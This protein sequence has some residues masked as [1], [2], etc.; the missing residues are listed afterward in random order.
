MVDV[1]A[2]ADKRRNFIFCFVLDLR[3]ETVLERLFSVESIRH[4]SSRVPDPG[5]ERRIG[6][7]FLMMTARWCGPRVGASN[8]AASI[9]PGAPSVILFQTSNREGR[10][11]QHLSLYQDLFLKQFEFDLTLVLRADVGAAECMY[12]IIRQSLTLSSVFT[13]R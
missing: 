6:N 4:S 5:T 3:A 7:S 2:S 13:T 11:R 8:F 12:F 1:V 10:F 9:C